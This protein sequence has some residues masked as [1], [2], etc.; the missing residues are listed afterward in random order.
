MYN[1]KGGVPFPLCGPPPIFFCWGNTLLYN[2]DSGL[3]QLALPRVG[4]ERF[5][6]SAGG[7]SAAGLKPRGEPTCQSKY[8]LVS[9]VY[10]CPCGRF[11]HAFCG[12]GIG[13]EGYGQQRD[14]SDCQKSKGGDQ[15][16][17]S[18][19]PMEMDDEENEQDSRR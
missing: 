6:P 1:N 3:L 8:Q 13:E 19:S 17:S 11:M 5:L 7:S 18:S 16:G 2:I 4:M 14:C 12:R 10:Q 9:G 15:V